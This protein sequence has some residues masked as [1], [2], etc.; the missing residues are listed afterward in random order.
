MTLVAVIGLVTLLVVVAFAPET[1]GR[2]V[3]ELEGKTA[4]R[5]IDEPDGRVQPLI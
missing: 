1:A 3:K 5:R 4:A 2:S